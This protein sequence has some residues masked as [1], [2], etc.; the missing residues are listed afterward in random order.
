MLETRETDFCLVQ[1]FIVFAHALLLPS[2]SIS[3]IQR[4]HA[5]LRAR[6]CRLR[7]A[8]IVATIRIVWL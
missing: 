5:P 3:Q 7:S 4:I 2:I 6:F 8:V 1:E